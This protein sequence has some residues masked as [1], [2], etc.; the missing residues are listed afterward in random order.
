LVRK[1]VDWRRAIS[2]SDNSPQRDVLILSG[3]FRA[4][5]ALVDHCSTNMYEQQTM[6][7]PILF[8]YR[9]ALEMAMKCLGA[10]LPSE[11]RK[12]SLKSTR[13][14]LTNRWYYSTPENIH[15]TR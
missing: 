6:I 11:E 2:F 10:K 12:S 7:Y 14:R 13:L 8:C 5:H 9:H 4:P 15:E 3:Y 1:A